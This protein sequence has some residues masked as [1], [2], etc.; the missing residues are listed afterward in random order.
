MATVQTKVLVGTTVLTSKLIPRCEIVRGVLFG[1]KYLSNPNDP[2][3]HF[4]V[5]IYEGNLYIFR[6]SKN[7]NFKLNTKLKKN[8]KI[9][10]LMKHVIKLEGLPTVFFVDNFKFGSE[11]GIDEVYINQTRRLLNIIPVHLE[12]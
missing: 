7:V 3:C 5:A 9:L 6:L 4:Y 8:V 1:T 10:F 2:S 11:L 12:L